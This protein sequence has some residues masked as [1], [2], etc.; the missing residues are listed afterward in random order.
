MNQETAE[1]AQA[2]ST[3]DTE[4]AESIAGNEA[5]FVEMMNEKA[6]SLGLCNTN[7]TNPHGLYDDNHYTTAYDLA[8]I[9]KH[10][11]ENKT[12]KE[13]VSTKKTVIPLNK[14]DGSR[15]LVNHNKLLTMYE[16]AIGVKTGFTKKCGRCLVSAA[17]KN[18]TTIIAV[19]LNAPNDWKDHSVM[20]DMGFE[21]ITTHQLAEIGS[22]SY[23]LP[24]VGGDKSYVTVSNDNELKYTCRKSDSQITSE[25]FLDRFVFAPI[26]AGETIGQVVFYDNGTEIGRVDLIAK[27]SVKQQAVKKKRFVFF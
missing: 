2:E 13:I 15:V 12:F 4:T 10:A 23:N 26:N 20:L 1:N 21:N 7:F 22:L 11:L 9:T 25:L 3:E 24:V 8:V 19:T 27:D 17:E 14:N 16:G 5:E 18:G 6:K